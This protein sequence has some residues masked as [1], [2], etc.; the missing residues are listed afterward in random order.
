MDAGSIVLTGLDA[1]VIVK[2]VAVQM[3]NDIRAKGIC[4][5]EDYQ[6]T[7]TAHRVLKIMLGTAKLSNSWYGIQYNDLA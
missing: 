3:A 2:S 6:I 4:V 7:N 1:N 5:P